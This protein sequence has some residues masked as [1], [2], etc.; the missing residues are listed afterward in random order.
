MLAIRDQLTAKYYES[1]SNSVDE[2]TL[3]RNYPYSN[4]NNFSLTKINSITS[5]T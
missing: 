1:I 4:F 3:V 2:P 5:K